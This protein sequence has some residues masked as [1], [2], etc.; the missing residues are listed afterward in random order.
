MSG[1]TDVTA[2]ETL[3]TE[4]NPALD[5]EAVLQRTTDGGFRVFAIG[6]SGCGRATQFTDIEAA[7]AG[8]NRLA[9]KNA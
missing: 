2:G 9:F 8:F 1:I 4:Y 7:F 5:V 3:Q 6:R